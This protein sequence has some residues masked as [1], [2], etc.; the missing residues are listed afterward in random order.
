MLDLG[1]SD[2]KQIHVT[3]MEVRAISHL[4]NTN[5]CPDNLILVQNSHIPETDI[6]QIGLCPF[7]LV[8]NYDDGR[9]PAV[10]VEAKCTKCLHKK[11]STFAKCK[12][13]TAPLNVT[14]LKH[15]RNKTIR[16]S[17][18]CFCASVESK[19]LNTTTQPNSRRK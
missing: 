8:S 2:P 11:C 19:Q 12:E 13:I 18:G 3:H 5:S 4:L 7:E 9:E 14:Y 6:Q 10:I 16:R 17:I 1:F 15:N